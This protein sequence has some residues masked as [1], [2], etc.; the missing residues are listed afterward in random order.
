MSKLDTEHV[1]FKQTNVLEPENEEL[2]FFPRKD[3]ILIKP[4]NK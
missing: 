1:T 4:I 3:L 2:A